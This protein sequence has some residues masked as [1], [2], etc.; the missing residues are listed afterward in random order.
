M[1]E[2]SPRQDAALGAVATWLK[3]KPGANG[4]PLVFRLFGYAGT[5]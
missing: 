1:T 2:F 5:G 3:A 4:T